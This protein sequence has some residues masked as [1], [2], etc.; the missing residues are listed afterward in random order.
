MV[1]IQ[2]SFLSFNSPGVCWRGGKSRGE[3]GGG[4]REGGG[5]RRSTSP[6]PSLL[7]FPP[8]FYLSPFIPFPFS[9]PSHFHHS[10]AHSFISPTLSFGP[11][12]L[13]P[14]S[15]SLTSYPLFL[16]LPPPVFTSIFS[17]LLRFLFP[18]TIKLMAVNANTKMMAEA[19]R[20]NYSSCRL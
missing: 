9:C 1:R 13:H 4:L 17:P 10:L 19:L 16:L 20:R 15:L 2:G 12:T 3:G 18:T 6:S 8:F 7:P 11:L 14:S 5:R